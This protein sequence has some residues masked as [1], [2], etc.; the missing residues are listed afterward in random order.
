MAV[1]TTKRLRQI[2]RLWSL[3]L[4]LPIKRF[5]YF[6]R[7][8]R[9]MFVDSKNRVK[10]RKMEIYVAN[11]CNLNCLFCSHLNPFRKGTIP[12]DALISAMETWCRKVTPKKLGLLGGE[13]LLHPN[14]QEIIA[15]ARR[16]WPESEIV[17]TSN[18]LLFPQKS[19]ALLK[20]L[21]D[22]RVHVLLSRHLTG[23]EG[24]K[25]FDSILKRLYDA[26]VHV[27]VIPSSSRWKR[28][29][30][31][32][33]NGCPQPFESRPEHAWTMCGPNTCFNLTNNHLYR[34]S[35]L[36]NAALAFQEGAVGEKWS[37]TQSYKPLDETSTTDE[38]VSHLHLFRGPLPACSIC[39]ET[40]VVVEAEQIRKF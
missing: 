39:P 25:Q 4:N 14:L 2:K 17:L 24:E 13:P 26:N 29:Y 6:S 23:D 16:C 21:A 38:I 3:Y 18:G 36:A 1:I 30:N 7:L 34:C 11:G 9:R 19:E 8:G 15:A 10:I 35:I 20:E 5:L 12:K 28:Y 37:V 32:D 33:E 40:T 31:M 27:T 22:S